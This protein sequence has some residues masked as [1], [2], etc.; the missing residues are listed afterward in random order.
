MDS[1]DP[2]QLHP[3]GHALTLD[4]ME[5]FAPTESRADPF[6]LADIAAKRRIVELLE[7]MP[8]DEMWYRA[9]TQALRLL[10][11]SY[12]DRPGYDPAWAPSTDC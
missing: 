12:A 3:C 1:C 9:L 6:V 11:L 7:S 4:Q 2:Y 8:G 10:A 5:E